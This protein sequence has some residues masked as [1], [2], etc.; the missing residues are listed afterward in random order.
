[1]DAVIRFFLTKE[2]LNYTLFVFLLLFG[3][4]SYQTIPKDV[5]P[6]LQLDKIVVAGGY[7]GASVETLDKMVVVKL[8]KGLKGVNGVEKIESYIKNGEFSIILRLQSG[9]D[10]TKILNKS[11]DVISNSKVDFPSDMDEPIASII[12][13]SFPLINITIASEKLSK[14]EMIKIAD[15]IKTDLST[16]TNVSK[17]ELYE[18][19]T[20]TFEIILDSQKIDLYGLDKALLFH[21]IRQLS[22]IYPM[23]KIEDQDGHLYLSTIN[24]KKEVEAYLDTQIKVGER[25]IYLGDIAEVKE[26]YKKTDIISRLNGKENITIGLFK[27]SQANAI[28][29]VEKIKER[30]NVMNERYQDAD[31]G[32]FYDTSIYIKN[33]LNTVISG[34]M[35]G[36]I[37]VAFALYILINK[38]VAF[39]VVMG[40]PTAILLG[41]ALLSLTTYSI[42]M[43]TLIG[44]LLIL[45]VLVDDAVII[46]ENIQRHISMG[47]DKLQAAI[48]GTKEVLLPVTA[49]SITTTFAFLPMLML[50]GEIGE[51]LK[52]I[53]IAVVILIITS[54][55]E[56]FV[57][58][59]IHSL[60][61]LDKNDKEL[62]WSKA[63]ELYSKFLHVVIV[64]RKK[65][66]LFFLVFI[67]ALTVLIISMMRYQL[68]PTF[69]SDKV[70]IRGKYTVNHSVQDTYEKTKMIE[71]ILLEHKKE[72]AIKTLSFSSGLRTD[73]EEN[74]EIKQSVFQFNMELHDRMPTNFVDGFITPILSFDNADTPKVR[75]KSVDETVLKIKELLKAFK[76]EGL[77]EFSIKKEGAGVT[78]ND[79]EILFNTKDTKVLLEAIESVKTELN[80]LDGIIFVDD[81]AKFGVKELKLRLNHYGESLGFNEGVLAENLTPLFLRIEQTKGLGKEGIFEIITYDNRRDHFETLSDLEVTIPESDQMVRLSEICDFTYVNNFDS[82]TKV[83]RIDTKKVVANVNTELLTA[84]EALSLLEPTFEAL[85]SKG[86]NI[87]LEGEVE[88]NKKMA[89]EMSFAFFVAIFLIFITLLVMFDSFKQTLMI[90]SIIPLSVIGALAGHL[91]MG[92]NLSITSVVGILGLAG[93]VVN[94]AIVMLDFVRKSQSLEEM[95]SRAKLRL[96]PILITS[97]TTFLGLS[98]LIFFATG[99]AKI[100]QPIALS[101]GFGLMWGTILT[102]IYLPA[103][104]AVVTKMKRGTS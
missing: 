34:I 50:T 60:H 40:I 77:T 24:G 5:Y 14:D 4:I 39:I 42:N 41:V 16:I 3:I 18:D 48:N 80:K 57:F 83:N 10:K 86:V 56:S 52:L 21:Q 64:H 69:D 17:V 2:R 104:F 25:V 36:L 103:L 6:P 92:L 31:I 65:F 61:L 59:P 7:A 37:L 22:Y 68:F 84:G 20:K 11:K 44:A 30:V 76:P 98:T 12:D 73:N 8:E 74:I 62:D 90:L 19:T 43:I 96:R 70:Y 75:T 89:K 81:T 58:L 9:S 72:L 38:R 23:G 87:L 13:W 55:L 79:I 26:Q 51:F 91:I 67:P 49:S 45:G 94:D 27:N 102:L 66:L 100:L 32:T 101:L 1:M 82:I 15:V 63:Q 29:L 35:F 33:R 95:M 97:L 47:D 85:R 99:Q 93:V 53:P 54:L 28:R 71:R 46:A 88:Q 78:A